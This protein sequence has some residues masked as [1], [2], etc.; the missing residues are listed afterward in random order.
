MYS[1]MYCKRYVLVYGEKIKVEIYK[2]DELEFIAD[3]I[4][5]AAEYIGE[6]TCTVI[7][8]LKQG[9]SKNGFSLERHED[10]EKMGDVILAISENKITR[11]NS[12]RACSRAFNISRSKLIKLIDE[13]GVA[14]DGR[15]TFDIPFVVNKKDE[16]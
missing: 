1:I 2:D 6:K 10:G 16:E 15:T 12:Y 7:K 13:G 4:S 5:H 8:L 9:G 14:D 11:Y 3:D